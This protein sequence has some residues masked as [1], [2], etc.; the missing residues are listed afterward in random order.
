MEWDGMEW[1]GDCGIGLRH[2]TT[3]DLYVCTYMMH[4]I[5]CLT[6]RAAV[7]IW[8][9][10]VRACVRV[11]LWLLVLLPPPQTLGSESQPALICMYMSCGAHVHVVRAC[12]RHMCHTIPSPLHRCNM[13][14]L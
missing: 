3:N 9:V 4:I 2:F 14:G 11:C 12:Q 10:C 7:E 5:P 8:C 6:A 13:C 1:D